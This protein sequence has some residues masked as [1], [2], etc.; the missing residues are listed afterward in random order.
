MSRKRARRQDYALHP[1]TA[2]GREAEPVTLRDIAQALNVSVAT[3]SYAL[4]GSPVVSAATRERVLSQAREMGYR[5]NPLVDA[6]M[7]SRRTHRASDRT[8]TLAYLDLFAEEHGYRDSLM[9][10]YFPDAARE[11][12]RHGFTMERIRARD[13]AISGKRL[14]EVLYARGVD[15]VLLGPCP[16]Q[17][18]PLDFSWE[19]FC[20]VSLTRAP[21]MPDVE[22]VGCNFF[23]MTAEVMSRA[24]ALGGKRIGLMLGRSGARSTIQARLGAY[25]AGLYDYAIP[26]SAWL[27][28]FYGEDWTIDTLRR[29]LKRTRP[30]TVIGAINEDRLALLR[31]IEPRIPGRL[32]VL[33]VIVPERTP[34][35]TGFREDAGMVAV[36]ATRHLIFLVQSNDRGV[37]L[38][39]RSI[40]IPGQWNPGQTTSPIA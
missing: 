7:R 36:M 1:P 13:P 3:V 30:D 5:R 25:Y 6:L 15:G 18:L 14:C 11:A 23:R 39:P 20:W 21:A 33:S 37:P 9:P 24:V 38:H 26:R 28:P 16:E 27:E 29:W 40:R 2:G 34:E 22:H 32:N 35:L 4:S 10:D 19:R 8:V 12:R 17:G 31:Q